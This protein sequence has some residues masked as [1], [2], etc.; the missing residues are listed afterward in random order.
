MTNIEKSKKSISDKCPIYFNEM[1]S[2][3]VRLYKT[4]P[5][6]SYI[7]HYDKMYALNY[8]EYVKI[9][10]KLLSDSWLEYRYL[11]NKV[12]LLYPN[13]RFTEHELKNYFM[14]SRPI[15]KCD[16]KSVENIADL[17][18][19]DKEKIKIEFFEQGNYN[20]IRVCCIPQHIPEHIYILTDRLHKVYDLKYLLHE[21]GHAI[22]LSKTFSSL[23]LLR[24]YSYNEVMQE[25]YAYLYESLVIYNS[26]F[27]ETNDI[28]LSQ[29]DI[30]NC[31]LEDLYH[32]RALAA[33]IIY[34]KEY[35]TNDNEIY[36]RK[37]YQDIFQKSLLMN[38]DDSTYLNHSVSSF[39]NIQKFVGKIIA[40][41]IKINLENN[42][43]LEWYRNK[44]A[45]ET[46]DNIFSKG[47]L[48]TPNNYEKFLDS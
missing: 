42:F 39:I 17:L 27:Q 33:K 18:I 46:L 5:E 35:F 22:S 23:V 43:G 48:V 34:Q 40:S 29:L 2:G 10:Y 9:A 14:Q 19:R 45:Y 16:E 38:I 30:E 8:E 36:L 25:A 24:A 44:N 37:F 11:I 6:I 4:N 3:F 7:E 21:L 15:T 28:E 26:D 41:K 31:R 32:I 1:K 13:T 20:D 47:G 12:K